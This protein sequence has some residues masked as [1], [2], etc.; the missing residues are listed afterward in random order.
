MFNV[1]N[2]QHTADHITS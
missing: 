2:P 1:H